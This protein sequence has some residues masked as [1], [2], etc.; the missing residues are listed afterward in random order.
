MFSL[1]ISLSLRLSLAII[2]A[3]ADLV[4]TH[5]KS[6][7][8]CSRQLTLRCPLCVNPTCGKTKAFF[9]SQKL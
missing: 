2:Q 6:N 3:L 5:L 4:Q 9:S 1:L 7:E 8:P